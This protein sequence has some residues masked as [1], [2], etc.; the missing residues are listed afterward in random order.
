[1]FSVSGKLW[2]K[3]NY[4]NGEKEGLWETFQDN[5]QIRYTGNYKNNEKDGL[6]KYYLNENLTI[7]STW[8]NGRRKEYLNSETEIPF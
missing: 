1:M 8:E 3:Q 6:W 5:G 4:K 2:S 7:S